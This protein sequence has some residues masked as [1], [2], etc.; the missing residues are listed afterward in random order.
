MLKLYVKQTLIITQT[1]IITSTIVIPTALHIPDSTIFTFCFK[2]TILLDNF[3]HVLKSIYN[4]A[5]PLV[6]LM[7]MSLPL[8][9][10]SVN[11]FF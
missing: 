5:G 9:C 4:A 2:K 6:M 1:W 3:L 11:N 10:K 7:P 8:Y